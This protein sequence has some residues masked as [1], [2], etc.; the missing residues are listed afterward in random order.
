MRNAIKI[1]ADALPSDLPEIPQNVPLYKQLS[2][3][4]LA[5]CLLRLTWERLLNIGVYGMV[6]SAVVVDTFAFNL[7]QRCR[8]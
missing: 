7:P 3:R 5:K 8:T 1:A 6:L 4:P 2:G